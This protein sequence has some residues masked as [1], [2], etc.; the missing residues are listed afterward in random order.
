MRKVSKLNLR[1]RNT[2]QY[3]TLTNSK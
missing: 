1:R 3:L 2:N